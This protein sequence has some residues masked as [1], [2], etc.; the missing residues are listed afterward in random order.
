M[1]VSIVKESVE[2]CIENKLF[3]IF[4][5]IL[6]FIFES[7]ANLSNLII[8][9]PIVLGIIMMGYGLQVTQDIIHG[10]VRL[11][12]IMPKKVIVF[13]FKGYFVYVVYIFIEIIFLSVISLGLNFPEFEL[14]DLILNYD[15]TMLLFHTHD[16][17]SFAIFVLSGLIIVYITTFFMELSLARLADGGKLLNSF[18]FLKI[19]RAIDIIGWK[20]Y[21]L[22][23]TKIILLIVMFTHFIHYSAR[24]AFVDTITDTVFNFLIFVI[25]YVGMANVYKVYV[26][27]K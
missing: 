7:F 4:I 5:L 27:N 23:Y 18:N 15:K 13:G 19:K 17:V 21:A 14:R 8:I 3:F 11:P 16:P 22:E 6:Y 25:Q 20:N 12:K 26:D 2:Y 10:G 24:F 1:P 9:T